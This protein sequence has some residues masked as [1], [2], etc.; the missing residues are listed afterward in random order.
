MSIW[1]NKT[2]YHVTKKIR[3]TGKHYVNDGI[4]PALLVYQF[5]HAERGG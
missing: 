2:N 1:I 4:V 3:P 5:V